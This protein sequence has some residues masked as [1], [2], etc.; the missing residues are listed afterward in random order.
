MFIALISSVPS[1][2]CFMRLFTNACLTSIL[3]LLALMQLGSSPTYIGFGIAMVVAVVVFSREPGLRCDCLA[4]GRACSSLWIALGL[5]V[6]IACSVMAWHRVPSIRSWGELKW[7][8]FFLGFVVLV[9]GF[10]REWRFLESRK[11]RAFLGFL[12]AVTSFSCFA[13]VYQYLT[14]TDPFRDAL[15]QAGTVNLKRGHGLLRN[16]VPFAKLMGVIALLGVSGFLT[17]IVAGRRRWAV[18]SALLTIACGVAVLTSHSRGAWVAMAVVGIAGLVIMPSRFRKT[19]TITLLACAVAGIVTVSSVPA[20]QHR[21]LTIFE[22]THHQANRTRIEQWH[23]NWKILEN[24][25]LGVGFDGN[26]RRED[27]WYEELGYEKRVTGHSHNEFIEIA[28]ATGWP[29]LACYLFVTLLMLWLPWR[30]LRK[31]DIEARPVLAFLLCSSLLVQIFVNGA[32]M[33]DQMDTQSRMVMSL[34]WAVA[35]VGWWVCE[36]GRHSGGARLAEGRRSE[37]S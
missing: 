5:F 3:L 17:S 8:F 28:V 16:P 31:L 34:A 21:V 9:L 33:T 32:V 14:Q 12:F 20:L 15:G 2:S 11:T 7:I 22:D 36:S 1:H 26:D 37:E 30:A 10:F 13:A 29:G 6:L 35:L 25:P 24:N 18:L 4:L 19:W 23:I 27:R